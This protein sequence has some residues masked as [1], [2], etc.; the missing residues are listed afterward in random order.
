MFL[1]FL[2]TLLVSR[3]LI[4]ALDMSPTGNV[5]VLC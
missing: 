1:Q 3:Y 5:T 2:L 4:G